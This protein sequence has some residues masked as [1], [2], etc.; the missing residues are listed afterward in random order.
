MTPGVTLAYVLDV[1]RIWFDRPGASRVTE[2]NVARLSR[3]ARKWRR[4]GALDL[5]D[6]DIGWL[7]AMAHH[8][9]AESGVVREAAEPAAPV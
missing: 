4:S 7:S 5:A 6:T 3:S 2:R 1:D 8:L 9:A